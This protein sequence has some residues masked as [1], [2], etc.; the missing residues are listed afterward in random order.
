VGRNSHP[1]FFM[2]MNNKLL[3]IILFIKCPLLSISIVHSQNYINKV[4]PTSEYYV[5]SA[6][7]KVLELDSNLNFLIVHS[8]YRNKLGQEN[9][10]CLFDLDEKIIKLS[11]FLDSI[12]Y[13]IVLDIIPIGN[14][15]LLFGLKYNSITQLS[16]YWV[17]RLNNNLDIIWTNTL[18]GIN[19]RCLISKA[20]KE[21]SNRIVLVGNDISVR[22]NGTWL[23]NNS[24]I[25]VI[26]SN[27]VFKLNKS[28]RGV[29]SSDLE[30][31][32]DLIINKDKNIYACGYAYKRTLDQE[33]LILKL[34]PDGELLWRKQIVEPKYNEVL[35]NIFDQDDGSI[36]CLGDSYDGTNSGN[37]FSYILLMNIDTSGKVNW[38]KRII[39]GYLNESYNCIQSHNGDIICCGRY[40]ANQEYIKDGWI[41]KFTSSGDSLWSR[42]I[43]HDDSIS[44]GFTY[45][46]QASDGGYYLTGYSWVPGDNSSKAWIVKTDSFGCVVPGCEKVVS[47]EDIISGKEK[48]FLFYPNPVVSKKFFFLSRIGNGESYQLQIHNL[49]GELV[50]TYPFRAHLGTQ[51]EVDINSSV[52]SGLY[53]VNVI[54]DLG[55]EV[56]SEKMEVVR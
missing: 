38:T 4:I 33:P 31:Y 2:K 14:S 12:N 11:S 36:L 48:A 19:N 49:Q 3:A 17:A 15:Y 1:T 18:R 47:V 23:K 13:S 5:E 45:I 7:S 9:K 42:V 55:K 50:Q 28:I 27:G 6:S 24:M 40:K 20:Y 10:L 44:E 53:V 16:D 46:S 29:D 26:D 43:N 54:N 32:F 56:A 22:S 34:S 37:E 25:L 52:S 51:Y 8:S 30:G 35:L 39:K 21:E 41:V